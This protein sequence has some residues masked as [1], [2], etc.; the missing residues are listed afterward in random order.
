MLRSLDMLKNK[1]GGNVLIA[2]TKTSIF[3]IRIWSV[4]KQG[5]RIDCPHVCTRVEI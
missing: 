1:N 5:L 3:F 4:F 2:E